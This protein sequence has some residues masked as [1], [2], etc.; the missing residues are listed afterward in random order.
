M[1][2]TLRNKSRRVHQL[3]L[4]LI[5]LVLIVLILIFILLVLLVL[6]FVLVVHNKTS[7]FL[8]RQAAGI[9]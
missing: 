2:G 8:L 4:V 5:L 1:N 7:I 9:V 6:I 3:A